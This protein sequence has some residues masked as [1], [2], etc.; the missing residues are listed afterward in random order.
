MPLQDYRLIDDHRDLVAA[1]RWLDDQDPIGVDVERAD[2]NRYYR[3]AALVQ[4]GGAGR[5]ALL[6][7]LGFDDWQPLQDF[8]AQRRVVLHALENDIAPLESLGVTP[9]R[10]EDTA[11]AAAVLGLPMG[12]EALLEAELGV[13]TDSD[14]AAMQR[15]DWEARP[16]SAEMLVYAAGDVADLPELWRRLEE[17]LVATERWDWY[18]EEVAARQ[19]Q[20]TVEDRRDWTRTKGVGR[21][22]PQA[23]ARA[24][25]LWETREDLAKDTDTAPGRIVNDKVLLDLAVKPPKA[26]RELGRRGV[27]RQ[28]VRAFG[29]DLLSALVRG[30]EADPQPMRMHGRRRT[31]DDREIADRLRSARAEVAERVGLDAGFLCPSRHLLRAV[32]TDPQTPAELRDALGLRDWQWELLRDTFVDIVFDGRDADNADSA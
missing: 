9:T 25:E 28:A 22:D 20:P 26:V 31:D 8:L 10:L 24:K 17:R 13:V 32:M 19:T 21:L 11:L 4:V 15:A 6:D 1:L 2:W 23:R 7:P 16:L 18:R 30:Q 14:K 27:R 29:E 3:A 12:L 5:V